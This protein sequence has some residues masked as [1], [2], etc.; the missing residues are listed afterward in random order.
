MNPLDIVALSRALQVALADERTSDTARFTGNELAYL[1][2]CLESGRVSTTGEYVNRFESMLCDYTG[3]GHAIAVINGTAALHLCL[4]LVG[5]ERG[6]EVLVPTLTFVATA[7]AVSYCGATP[8]FVDSEEN[9]LGVCPTKLSD[10]LSQISQLRSGGCFNKKT[11]ARI[12]ALVAMHT[13]GHPVDLDCLAELCERYKLILVEDA[14]QSLGSFYRGKHTGNFGKAAAL[15]FNGNKVVTTGGGGAL[16]TND[17]E[18]AR[19]ARHIST[20]AR[21]QSASGQSVY[22]QVGYNYRMPA[23]NAALGCAQ[24]EKL[25]E[26]ISRKRALAERY[27]DSIAGLTGVEFFQEPKFAKSNYWMNALLLDRDQAHLRNELLVQ[28]ATDGFSTRP[29]WTLM[30]KL[31]TYQ[32]CPRMCLEGAEELEQRIVTLPSEPQYFCESPGVRA[33]LRP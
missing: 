14:A 18:A 25:P 2:D 22:D 24:M 7:N 32:E 20:N 10:H 16:L 23:I 4:K 3:A 31:K 5:V 26:I 19:L 1:Q 12:R 6:D 28:T 11:G 33:V 29:V 15:S 27:R 21:V 13:F 30:H 17:A 9:T 8:H